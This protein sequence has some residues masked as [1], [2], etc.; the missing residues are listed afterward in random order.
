MARTK[1]DVDDTVT[2]KD[3]RRHDAGRFCAQDFRRFIF[4]RYAGSPRIISARPTCSARR[5][6]APMCCI[7]AISAVWRAAPSRPIMAAFGFSISG[8][9]IA[10]GRYSQKK[11]PGAQKAASACGTVGRRGPHTPWLRKEPHP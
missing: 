11:N 4:R 6:C 3:D 7:F 1:D 5:K 8:R 10:T 9:W 2:R